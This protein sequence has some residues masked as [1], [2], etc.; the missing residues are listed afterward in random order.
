MCGIAGWIDL[1]KDLS[2]QQKIIEEMADTL[3]YRGPDASGLWISPH[4]L[5]AHRRLIVIDPSGGSQPMIRQ[6]GGYNYVIT[7]NG[8]LYNTADLRNVLESRGHVFFS[9][10]DTEVLLMSYIEWGPECVQYLNGIYAFGVWSEKDQSLFLARDRFGVKPLFYAEHGSSLIFGSELKAILAHPLIKPEVDTEGL[11]EVF[12]LG[13]ARTPGHGVFKGISEVK[14][15]CYILYDSNGV[16][17]RKYWSLESYPHEDSLEDTIEKLSVLVKDAVVRQLV[18]D[19][20]VCTF[21]SGGLDSSAITAIAANHFRMTGQ[22]QL[23][24]YSIDYVDNE[25]Y[26]K[27]SSF[28]PNSDGPWVKR[29]SEEFNTCHHYIRFDTPQLVESL[30]SA[31]NARDLPGMADVDSSLWLFCREIK[32]DV[33]VA[34]SGEC[35]DEIFGGYPWFHHEELLN[36]H[37][38]P[39]ARSIQERTRVLSRELIERIKPEEYINRRYL[40]TLEEVPRLPGENALE[41]RR[42]ELFYLNITWFMSTL[43]ERKDRMSMAS[44]LEVRVPYCDHRLVQYVWNIPWEMK[45]LEGR[46]KGLLRQALKGVLPDDVLYRKKSPYPKTHNPSYEAEVKKWMLEI[47]YDSNSPIKPLIDVKA[48]R[49]LAESESDYGKPWFGQLMATPQMFAYLIQVDVWLRKYRIRIM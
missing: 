13:P 2:T 37:T 29:M 16:H 17:M 5:I 49:S 30:I 35:A 15:A 7:Y 31:V 45:M 47:L 32:K 33:T 20:P 36:A 34:L 18:A 40:E 6:K 26:F 14:P 1:K 11:A 12:S 42:R 19:V 46:E 44:G 41:A 21:L 25:L 43:L 22:G 27:P 48:V 4:A 23:H 9:N 10:S 3:N 38:F 24:T 39:W 8:E 28:Q